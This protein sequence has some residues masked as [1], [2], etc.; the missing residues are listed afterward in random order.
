MAAMR[1]LL[2]SV[3]LSVSVLFFTGNATAGDAQKTGHVEVS[4]EEGTHGAEGEHGESGINWMDLSNKEIPPLIPMFLNFIVVGILVYFLLRKG[5]GAKIRDR[6]NEL[7]KALNEANALKAEAEAAMSEVRRRSDQLDSELAKLREDVLQSAR[8]QAAQIEKEAA[9]RA[10]RMQGESATLIAQEVA[11][12]SA[13]IRREAVEEIVQLAE[14][15]IAE[16]L[17]ETDHDSLAKEYVS[18]VMTA[19]Q[20]GK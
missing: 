18:S 11:M 6:K 17:T 15:R 4:G 8:A 3:L 20:A 2:L 1:L 10:E 13:R 12:M 14:K 5:L 16:K 7:E 9:I 19:V